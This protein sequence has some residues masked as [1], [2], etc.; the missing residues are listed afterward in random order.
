MKRIAVTVAVATL[1]L[2]GFAAPPSTP[3]QK[4]TGVFSD[5]RQIPSEGDVVGTEVF[6]VYAG[7]AYFVLL[8][9]AQGR[10]GTPELLPAI[11]RYPQLEFGI[12]ANTA[13]HCPTG[14]FRGTLSNRGL[15][16]SVQ[17]KEWPSF[18]PR[19]RSFWQ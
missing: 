9:C 10:I 16:G 19:K 14:D 8:Q 3:Q 4:I 12:P 7:S 1:P 2:S 6:L 15:R 5:L 18:L 11:V 13:T 17:G